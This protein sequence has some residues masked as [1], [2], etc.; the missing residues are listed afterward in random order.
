M[1]FMPYLSH[2]FQQ[3]QS[4]MI[5][6]CQA[7]QHT[8][9][10]CLQDERSPGSSSSMQTVPPSWM[11]HGPRQSHGMWSGQH[12]WLLCV[13]GD[14]AGLPCRTVL[15]S[16][17]ET[18]INSHGDRGIKCFEILKLTLRQIVYNSFA[19]TALCP[20][21]FSVAQNDHQGKLQIKWTDVLSFKSLCQHFK[22]WLQHGIWHN[23][24]L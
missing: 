16:T 23:I 9:W 2:P 7:G 1:T 18:V 14:R 20:E 17:G 6:R 5:L 8:L 21:S 19:W 15:L 13:H 10:G 11:Q 24:F 22:L 12:S 3:H 4:V